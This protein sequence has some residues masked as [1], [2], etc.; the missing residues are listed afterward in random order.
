MWPFKGCI[1]VKSSTWS[2]GNVSTEM[3]GNIPWIILSFLMFIHDCEGTFDYSFNIGCVCMSIS[4]G[5]FVC[6][7]PDQS[8]SILAVSVWC[9]KLTRLCGEKSL[10]SLLFEI[11]TLNKTIPFEAF[12]SSVRLLVSSVRK[13]SWYLRT[14]A[15]PSS[16]TKP[17]GEVFYILTSAA[18]L[19]LLLVNCLGLCR[20]M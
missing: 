1:F 5:L 13:V 12:I 7:A 6:L 20:T 4:A 16:L 19:R 14:A 15:D 3:E 11:F 2:F 18:L 9:A 8:V 10:F 17:N